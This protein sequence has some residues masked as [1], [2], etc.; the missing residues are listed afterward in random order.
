MHL[1]S[2]AALVQASR[3][4]LVQAARDLADFTRN[5]VH[6]RDIV[7]LAHHCER[8]EHLIT[9]PVGKHLQL[10][11]AL[12]EHRL[13]T[14]LSRIVNTAKEMWETQPEKYQLYMI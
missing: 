8:Y 14:G 6:A 10:E 3:R 2:Q 4:I 5:G 9:K 13:R 11:L 1:L 12:L 7:Q